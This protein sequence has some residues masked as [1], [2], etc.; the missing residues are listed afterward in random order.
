[1]TDYRVAPLDTAE[2]PWPNCTN[3]R[4]R[5]SG[6]CPAHTAA[7]VMVEANQQTDD[8]RRIIQSNEVAT[9]VQEQAAAFIPL[10]ERY[11]IAD[12]LWEQGMRFAA[13]EAYP[14]KRTL[15]LDLD[16][17]QWLNGATLQAGDGPR[18]AA[19]VMPGWTPE[20]VSEAYSAWMCAEPA[21]AKTTEQRDEIV[22]ALIRG[23][24]TTVSGS[25]LALRPDELTR[26]LTRAYTLG[27][28]LAI[29]APQPK[30]S[31]RELARRIR[32]VLDDQRTFHVDGDPEQFVA[33]APVL[34][35]LDSMVPLPDA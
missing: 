6:F 7:I 21:P 4:Q 32:L 10:T 27:A 2:C 25:R 16:T 22:D 33:L 11:D 20:L 12:A 17:G 3:A 31:A 35:A 1:M 19:S 14:G 8:R 34:A 18:M 13:A 28:S 26:I 24:D 5:R 29:N 15:V 9:T 30:F 23:S